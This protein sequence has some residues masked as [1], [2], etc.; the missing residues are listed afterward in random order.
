M[1]K[2]LY[3]HGKETNIVLLPISEP[4]LPG[5]TYFYSSYIEAWRAVIDLI[6]E[7]DEFAVFVV[8]LKY[9]DTYGN[10]LLDIINYANKKGLTIETPEEIAEHYRLLENVSIVVDARNSSLIKIKV[11]NNNTEDIG[12]LIIKVRTDG[13]VSINEEVARKKCVDGMCYYYVRL[14]IKGGEEKVLLLKRTDNVS[15]VGGT[16]K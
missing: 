1:P 4:I 13:N 5:A 3:H 7:S 2:S 16:S 11:L 8:K 9:L 12:N 10:I 6:A 14:N 15:V